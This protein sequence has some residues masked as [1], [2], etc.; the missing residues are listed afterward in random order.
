MLRLKLPHIPSARHELSRVRPWTTGNE[1]IDF[2]WD[3]SEKPVKFHLDLEPIRNRRRLSESGLWN[4]QKEFYQSAGIKAWSENMIPYAVTNSA[5]IVDAFAELAI[6]MFSKHKSQR[7]FILEGGSGPC[8]FGY[9]L[10][11]RIDQLMISYEIQD[12]EIQIILTDLNPNVLASRMA[13]PCFQ[14]LIR[15]GKVDF[16]TMDADQ[17]NQSLI[18]I[19]NHRPI[20]FDKSSPMLCIGNYFFD[21]LRSDIF[22]VQDAVAYEAVLVDSKSF[23]LSIGSV[24]SEDYYTEMYLNKALHHVL[25]RLE[26]GIIYF[27]TQALRF[28]NSIAKDRSHFGLLCTDSGHLTQIS[29]RRVNLTQLTPHKDCFCI[30]VDFETLQTALSS[31]L[32]LDCDMSSHWNSSLRVLMAMKNPSPAQSTLFNALLGTFSAGDVDLILGSLELDGKTLLETEFTALLEMSRYDYEMLKRIRWK[33][34]SKKCVEVAMKAY[35]NA[36]GLH[37]AD[38]SIIQMEMARWLYVAGDYAKVVEVLDSI[39]YCT[40]Q[41]NQYLLLQGVRTYVYRHVSISLTINS[42]PIIVSATHPRP[43]CFGSVSAMRPEK[44]DYYPCKTCSNRSSN[45]SSSISAVEG[46]SGLEATDISL[47]S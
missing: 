18:S 26:D 34:T 41:D 15:D 39:H 11:R 29:S 36:Y 46:F 45:T 10:A 20:D 21:S 4:K 14:D 37:A 9:L 31:T 25:S 44:S 17:I 24:V 8:Q 1:A 33:C 12:I 30:P 19:V 3:V 16:A 47:I 13:L 43:K 38:W 27:P 5:F 6:H 32:N 42:W 2:I 40:V 23:E 22:V 28:I 35:A 7:C